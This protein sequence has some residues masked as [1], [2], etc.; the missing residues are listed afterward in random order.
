M[1]KRSLAGAVT[2]SAKT[3][4]WGCGPVKPI[5]LLLCAFAR[6]ASAE[7]SG[8]HCQSPPN[9][10]LSLVETI[11]RALEREP[12]CKK[13]EAFLFNLGQKLNQVRQYSEAVDRLE[14]AI[15]LNPTHW[16]AHLEYAIA[17]EGMGDT[18]SVDGILH[19]LLAV[20]EIAPPLKRQIK[21]QLEKR[22]SSIGPNTAK[23]TVLGMAAGYDDNLMGA[24]RV[25]SFDLT[26]PS[27]RVPV[28]LAEADQAKGGR[29]VRLNFEHE[30]F[31]P[32]KSSDK[33]WSYTVNANYRL[34][35]DYT[36]ANFGIFQ[37]I[38]ERSHTGHEGIYASGGV[39]LM[40]S[41]TG[42]LLRHYKLGTGYD[43]LGIVGACRLRLGSELERR[44]YPSV[45]A[46]NG[47]YLGGMSYLACPAQGFQAQIRFGRDDPEY[48]I[49]PG[50]SQNQYILRLSKNTTWGPGNL[51]TEMELYRQEDQRGYSPLL[52]NNLKRTINRTLYRLEYR[53]QI[54]D[55]GPYVGIEHVDQNANLP[56]FHITNQVIYVGVR[57]VW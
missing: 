16:G 20:E 51:V 11:S 21:A 17:L 24:A 23:R 36:P 55:L 6:L 31:V 22:Q 1:S 9:A 48:D 49:R 40:Q 28:S 2:Q 42:A 25:S 53:T 18:A 35:P 15:L 57:A 39:L 14:A 32:E 19:N 30:G 56:L 37:F 34:S 54:S 38:L 46:L 29:F 8:A 26:L 12:E 4:D 44:S 47:H 7:S 27:G 52:E 43:A 50:A 41:P 3:S 45:D 5:A 33:T 13:N 10:G